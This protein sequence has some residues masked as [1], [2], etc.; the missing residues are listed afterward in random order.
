MPTSWNS[1]QKQNITRQN[2]QSWL[3]P[4]ECEQS[5]QTVLLRVVGFATYSIRLE[6]ARSLHR[7]KEHNTNTVSLFARALKEISSA[8]RRSPGL[9]RRADK[10]INQ[11]GDLWIILLGLEI[12]ATC[13]RIMKYKDYDGL[14]I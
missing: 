2:I 10:Q 7:G 11:N 14:C 4:T 8:L 1:T 3:K 9:C 6:T 12:P 13:M 5:L